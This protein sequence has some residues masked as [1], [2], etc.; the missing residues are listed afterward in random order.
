DAFQAAH[1]D[2]GSFVALRVRAL[3]IGMDAALGAEAMLDGV[4]VEGV[5]AAVLFRRGE[6]E[7]GARHEPQQRALALAH[8]A[9]AVDHRAD[10]AVDLE[11]DAAAMAA[12]LVF[13][14][15][16]SRWNSGD[17]GDGGRTRAEMPGREGGSL[18]H[19]GLDD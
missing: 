15:C 10:L 19:A 9:V 6:P 18:A 11:G 8:R 17:R 5:R 13:H 4:G 7:I 14:G 1:V 16:H 12:S 2:G 3:A